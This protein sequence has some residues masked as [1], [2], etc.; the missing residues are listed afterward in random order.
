MMAVM[1]MH[2]DT[3]TILRRQSEELIRAEVRGMEAREQLERACFEAV[4][5]LGC[6]VDE[7]SAASGLLPAEIRRIIATPR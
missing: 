7:V 5:K 3:L 6:S 1:L 2:T 4:T